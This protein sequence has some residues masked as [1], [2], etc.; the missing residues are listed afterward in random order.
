M[1]GRFVD[2]LAPAAVDMID[3]FYYFGY[4]NTDGDWV[5]PPDYDM[6]APNEFSNGCT[7]VYWDMFRNMAL[8][9]TEG[10]IIYSYEH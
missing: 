2:G 6:S 7:L 10:E 3:N 4:I 5:I 1:V 9:D 8:I